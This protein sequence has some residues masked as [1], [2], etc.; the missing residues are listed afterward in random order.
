MYGKIF[1]RIEEKYVIT[2]EQYEF[3]LKKISNHIERD[4]Y[5]EST[6]CNI[7]F[8]TI[9]NDLLIRSMDKPVYKMKVRLR[10]YGI[11]RKKDDVFLEVKSKHKDIVGK[12]R[13]KIKLNDF[14]KYIN[15]GLYDNHNQIMKESNVFTSMIYFSSSKYFFPASPNSNLKSSFLLRRLESKVIRSCSSSF[16]L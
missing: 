12:R 4:K 11:P 1:R 6:I 15:K 14:Y 3:L 8:D 16:P 9:Q 2:K 10:S 7:Y 5:F 13:V